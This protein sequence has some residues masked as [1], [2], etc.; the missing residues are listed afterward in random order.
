MP[1]VTL[2]IGTELIEPSEEVRNLGIIF[3][4]QMSMCA[5]ITGLCKSI[6]F[7]L[8]NVSRIRRFLDQDTCHLIIRSL[9]LSRLDYGNA[10]LLGINKSDLTRLQRLQ[11]WAA[12][13]IFCANKYDH[14]TPFL[15][16][17]HWLPINERIQF[18]II[19]FVFKCIN[20]IGPSY[21]ASM[22]SLYSPTRTGLRSS[23]DSTRLQE[24]RIHHGTLQSAANRS[25]YFSAPKL[26]NT[27]PPA[28][29]SVASVNVFKKQLK[30]HMF[31]L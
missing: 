16:E 1:S 10:L 27:L 26:W 11:N 3:D 14:V 12:K 6:S 19:L 15:K 8:R 23:T 18:K 28:L 29:R 30:S 7:Q 4:S 22:L 9:V 20:N 31:P 5:H 21:L 25:F 2:Q 17:L 24:H 13:L